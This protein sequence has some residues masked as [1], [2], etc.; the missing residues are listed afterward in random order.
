VLRRAGQAKFWQH[1]GAGKLPGRSKPTSLA[2]SQDKRGINEDEVFQHQAQ[3]AGAINEIR[4]E[5]VPW[6]II[7]I[8]NSSPVP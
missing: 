2:S 3:V 7:R 1:L 6:T 5:I 8:S 4:L